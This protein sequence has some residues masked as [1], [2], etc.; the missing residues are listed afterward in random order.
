[1]CELGHVLLPSNGSPQAESNVEE[2]LQ[3]CYRGWEGSTAVVEGIWM[4]SMCIVHFSW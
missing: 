1:M 4:G 3:R 2:I